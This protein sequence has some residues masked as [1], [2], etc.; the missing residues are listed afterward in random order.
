MPKGSCK[1]SHRSRESGIRP[2]CRTR[3]G[4]MSTKYLALPQDL[5]LTLPP[6]WK[7]YA[8]VT[9]KVIRRGDIWLVDFDPTTGHEQRGVR[10][11]V[12][13]S[14]D[15]MDTAVVGLAFVVPGTTRERLDATG[16]PLPN[17]LLAMPT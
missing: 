3:Q 13:I 7:E 14:S 6:S 9:P 5:S 15:F 1:C 2:I 10:P 4:R 12:V 8:S 17:H 16:R 11:A